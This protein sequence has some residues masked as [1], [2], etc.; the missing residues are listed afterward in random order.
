VSQN[1]MLLPR[2]KCELESWSSAGVDAS[3]SPAEPAW[4]K[5]MLFAP[6]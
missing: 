3:S 5:P 6:I 4:K 1:I 2:G